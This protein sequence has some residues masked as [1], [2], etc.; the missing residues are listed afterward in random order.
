M[1]L[2]SR[3]H[4]PIKMQAIISQ[5]LYL[6]RQAFFEKGRSVCFAAG[7]Q[8]WTGASSQARITEYAQSD[9]DTDIVHGAT[10]HAVAQAFDQDAIHEALAPSPAA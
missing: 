4:F 5:I 8:N 9:A 3:A 1:G 6:D 2:I 7:D 10:K